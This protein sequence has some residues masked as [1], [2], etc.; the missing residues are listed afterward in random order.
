MS[1]PG[2]ARNFAKKP[3]SRNESPGLQDPCH[4]CYILNAKN[5]IDSSF[6]VA[7]AA[8]II[9]NML[10]LYDLNSAMNSV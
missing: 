7:H 9:L 5:L 1:L 2:F 8:K 6:I 4:A 3:I 10:R